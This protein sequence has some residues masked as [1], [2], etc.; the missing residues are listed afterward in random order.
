MKDTSNP[1]NVFS[2]KKLTGIKICNL[3]NLC[4]KEFAESELEGHL[5]REHIIISTDCN[6]DDRVVSY[7]SVS[8]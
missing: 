8:Y 1:K 7:Q 3:C 5:S 6:K 4:N 2:S